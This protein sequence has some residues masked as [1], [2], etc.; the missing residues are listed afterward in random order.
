ERDLAEVHV[1][2]LAIERDRIALD[3]GNGS[4][5]CLPGIEI[6]GRQDNLVTDPPARR[7]QDLYGG[8]AC[9]GR[10]GQLGPG[11]LPVTVQAQGSAHDHDPAVTAVI[12]THS[13][14][15]FAFDVVGEGDGRLA[16]VGAGLAANLQLPMQHDPLGGQFKVFVVG[17]AEFA[18]DRHTA[19]RRW[20]DVED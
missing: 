19:Q 17:E 10:V 16:R 6:R 5:L 2:Q 18:V 7:V 1:I 8:A 15:V 4:S 12:S 13:T 14:K 3:G 11:V 20:T 9:G